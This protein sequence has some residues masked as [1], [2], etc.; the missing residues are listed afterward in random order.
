MEQEGLFKFLEF[1][2]THI[3]HLLIEKSKESSIIEVLYEK[4]P[5]LAAI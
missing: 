3:N 1:L 2:N 5:I 4:A